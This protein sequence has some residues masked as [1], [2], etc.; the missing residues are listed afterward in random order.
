[1]PVLGLALLAGLTVGIAGTAS[2][3]DRVA[4]DDDWCQGH[5][6]RDAASVCEVREWTYGAGSDLEVDAK[7]NGGIKVTAWE[8]DEVHVRAKVHGWAADERSARAIVD[9]IDVGVG[10]RVRAEGPRN[11]QDEG[12]SVSYRVMVPRSM[13]LELTSTNGGITIDGVRGKLRFSTTNGGVHLA[14]VGGDVSGRT[15][16]GGLHID[17]AGS[18]W[19]GDGL[20]VQTTNGGVEMSMPAGYSAR[21]EA[22]TTNGGFQIGFPVTVQGRIDRKLSVD[23]GDGGPTVRVKTTNGGIRIDQ[24]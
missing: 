14:A 18:R 22:S 4:S 10:S 8:R 9:R 2:A 21:L 13:D 6:R 7:P 1:V 24:S 15:T 5:E 12:W 11:N 16:N 17:L 3:Q 23:I 20:D 19:D